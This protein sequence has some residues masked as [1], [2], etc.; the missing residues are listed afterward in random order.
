[1]VAYLP[2]PGASNFTPAPA[3]LHRAVCYRLVDLGTQQR[4]WKGQRKTA[5]RVM[6]SWELADEFMDDGNP[7]SVS[8]FYTWSMSEK[9]NLRKD[10]EAWRGRQFEAI[11]FGPE[12]RFKPINLLGAPCMLN[13]VHGQKQSGDTRVEIASITPLAKGLEKPT[14]KNAKVFFDLDN[15]D[16]AV[17]DGLSDKI[18]ASIMQSPEYAA[19]KSGGSRPMAPRDNL[20]DDIPF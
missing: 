7:Y 4:E 17:F 15:F 8:N 9:A 18:K 2:E 6:L 13:V 16:Q 10:L 3:G 19:I 1:M 20:D 5:R 11:D 12:G 14:P